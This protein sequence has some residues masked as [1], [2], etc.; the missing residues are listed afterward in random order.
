MVTTNGLE[1]RL[2]PLQKE[3]THSHGLE[4]EHEHSG[5]AFTTWL[6]PT[7]AAEQASAIKEALAARWPQ[8]LGGC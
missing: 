2:I 6:D 7:L 1:E 5:T 8:A 4:G 3:A